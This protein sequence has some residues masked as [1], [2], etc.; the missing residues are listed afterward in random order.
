MQQRARVSTE[1]SSYPHVKYCYTS[2]AELTPV[3]LELLV[4][5]LKDKSLADSKETKTVLKDGVPVKRFHHC[6]TYIPDEVQEIRCVELSFLEDKFEEN[7]MVL[8]GK[9]IIS[10]VPLDKMVL[11]SLD[12]LPVLPEVQPPSLE[13]CRN[14][15]SLMGA[16]VS[17]LDPCPLPPVLPTLDEETMRHY[18]DLLSEERDYKLVKV[19]TGETEHRTFYVYKEPYGRC[20]MIVRIGSNHYASEMHFV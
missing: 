6:F 9:S 19:Q 15:V 14:L 10:S 11:G 18:I 5:H 1:D 12:E 20:Y 13:E 8:E 3:E 4:Q 17:A 2:L 16:K 7:Q